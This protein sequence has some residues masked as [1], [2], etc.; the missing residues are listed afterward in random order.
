MQLKSKKRAR[1]AHRSRLEED[2]YRRYKLPYE[3]TRLPYVVTHHYTP[4]WQV[5][6]TAFIE[7]KGLFT[8]ADRQKH[9]HIKKQ[10]PHIKVLLVFQDPNRKLSKASATTYASW[11]D[12]KGL[13]W[14]AVTDNA[15]IAAWIAQHRPGT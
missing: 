10:H 7:T 9:L 5:S 12:V 14:A 15:K 2:F 11:C 1:S 8:G 4:D 6:P 3:S 13:D